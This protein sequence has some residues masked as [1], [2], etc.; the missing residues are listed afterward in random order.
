[1]KKCSYCAE[2]IQD[3]AIV[4]RYCGRDLPGPSE[5]LEK[6]TSQGTE[7]SQIA[8]PAPKPSVWAQGAKVA[9]VFTVL[10]AI[11]FYIRY[12]NAPAEL[13]GNLTIGSVAIF[14]VWWLVLTGIISIWR[15]AGESPWGR[16][17]LILSVLF[18]I[19]MGIVVI[20][21]IP[22]GN[23][24]SIFSP[25]QTA[26]ELPT[27][28]ATESQ[29]IDPTLIQEAIDASARSNLSF[30]NNAITCD[31]KDNSVSITG[32]VLNK[33]NYALTHLEIIGWLCEN[34]QSCPAR[35]NFLQNGAPVPGDYLNSVLLG[36]TMTQ[37]IEAGH[38]YGFNIVIYT[39]SNSSL[40][41]SC[42]V[43]LTDFSY[44]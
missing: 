15:K 19:V 42:R 6:N 23:N 30:L 4:C 38:A 29:K 36:S 2:K 14:L 39:P 20:R 12:R 21:S 43:E 3:E 5:L 18:L 17:V 34:Q 1:M 37:T 26:I 13:I 41:Y 9:A 16:P 40:I 32:M 8:N 27:Q 22:N 7:K 28:T 10:A 25:T 24:I 11:G 44:P 35:I 33:N 31:R